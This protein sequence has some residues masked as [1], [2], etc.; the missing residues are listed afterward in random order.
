MKYW[1][2]VFIFPV[3][4]LLTAG[5]AAAQNAPSEN[6]G[7]KAEVLTTYA[8]GDQGLDDFK[9]R[10]FR[11]RRITVEPNGAAALHSHK[12]RPSL[13]YVMTGTLTEHREGAPA[14]EY[15]SGEVIS[16]PTSVTHWAE[17]KTSEPVVL[18]VVDLFKE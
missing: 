15:K 16:E 17:N 2:W 11:I 6:K 5:V 10:Q 1:S 14:R 18:I 3:G 12:D 9:N 13:A 8:L 4:C 7:M